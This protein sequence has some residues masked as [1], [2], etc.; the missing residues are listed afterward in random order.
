M[1]APRLAVVVGSGSVKC[2]GAVGLWRVLQRERIE[3]DL[4]V[5]C[6][7]GAVFAAGLA[8]GYGPDEVAALAARF[9]TRE[10]TSRRDRTVVPDQA[11]RLF[12][13]AGEP[14]EIRWWDSGHQLPTAAIAHAADWLAE[15]LG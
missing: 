13:A 1:S 10:A 15:R 6:S 9:F 5:G 12:D 3:V 14:K 2:A 11:Q 7:G 4:L 8:L